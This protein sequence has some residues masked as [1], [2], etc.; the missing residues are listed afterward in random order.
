MLY[1]TA[2]M[3]AHT[4]THAGTSTTCMYQM[5]LRTGTSTNCMCSSTGTTS[6]YQ[7]QLRT[8]TSTICAHKMLSKPQEKLSLLRAKLL[9][10]I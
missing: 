9:P 3:L 5:Q 2:T 6:M 4:T 8:G 7:M 1:S 10:I